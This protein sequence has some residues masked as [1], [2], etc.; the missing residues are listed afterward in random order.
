MR[1]QFN[2]GFVTSGAPL[3]AIPLIANVNIGKKIQIR[4]E[5]ITDQP[6]ES[7]QGGESGST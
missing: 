2:I 4:G 6:L 5:A 1:L 7:H 3:C